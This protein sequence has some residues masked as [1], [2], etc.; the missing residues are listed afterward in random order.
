MFFRPAELS[1]VGKEEDTSVRVD[2][3]WN[4]AEW[5]VLS[6]FSSFGVTD[7]SSKRQLLSATVSLRLSV[8]SASASDS[9]IAGAKWRLSTPRV[10]G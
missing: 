10:S 7:R 2:G 5:R 6:H 9:V 4:P 8:L 1:Q 3:R